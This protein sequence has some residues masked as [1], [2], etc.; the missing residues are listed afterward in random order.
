MK[1]SFVMTALMIAVIII[2]IAIAILRSSMQST[3]PMSYVNKLKELLINGSFTATYNR[4]FMETIKTSYGYQRTAQCNETMQYGIGSINDGRIFINTEETSCMPSN[5]PILPT[6]ELAYWTNGTSMCFAVYSMVNN[7]SEGT[8]NCYPPGTY[9]LL[10]VFMPFNE[11][12]GNATFNLVTSGYSANYSVITYIH[13]VNTTK[14][15][16]Q[17]TY[18][19]QVIS[20]ITLSQSVAQGYSNIAILTSLTCLLPNGLP[21][22][23]IFNETVITKS[24]SSAVTY[25]I[26]QGRSELINYT[27]NYFNTTAFNELIS[28]IRS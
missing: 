10:R 12:L 11:F 25:T 2:A 5:I 13:Y 27:L 17:A 21:A 20:N 15:N 18:C 23:T 19:F 3:L 1:R 4:S 7:R 9:P 26:M 24:S 14:W 16:G 22:I 28:K 6:V 8:I